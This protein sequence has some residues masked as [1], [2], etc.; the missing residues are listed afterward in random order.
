VASLRVNGN[1]LLGLVNE[2]YRLPF[3]ISLDKTN[4]L[5]KTLELEFKLDIEERSIAEK[6]LKSNLPPLV[7]PQ[8]ISYMFGISYNLILVMSIYQSN[9]YR[10]YKIPKAGHKFR[11]I[12][13]PRRFLKLVQRWIYDYM[14]S[15][16]SLP[17]EVH[18]F[19]PKKDIF[20]NARPHLGAKNIMVIDI[21][22]FFPSIKKKSVRRVFKELG[23]PR[24]VSMRLTGL[25]TFDGRLPQGAPTS[26]ALAN[27]I[28]SPIDTE[29][30]QIA[31][32]WGCEYTRYADDLVF[33]GNMKFTIKE[34]TRIVKLI[35]E[36]GFKINKKKSRIIGSGGRQ[37]VAGIVVNQKGLP[38][39]NKRM[40]WRAT[41]HQASLNPEKYKENGLTLMG[42]A[43]FVN[44]YNSNLA[45]KYKQIAQKI[46]E[47]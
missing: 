4:D 11:Q 30:V 16:V 7:R 1:L 45:I 42:I 26:P 13:A 29:L 40:K 21:K 33:S 14:L 20:T 31:K 10:V 37:I 8:M 15:P 44:R 34:K 24:K 17:S 39:R 22:D 35:E 18:G 19:T 9:Y 36:S 32:E 47:A 5:L 6:L 28:F 25:C 43:S 38:P 2:M 46:I 3:A 27:I 41:F 23:F 12:E